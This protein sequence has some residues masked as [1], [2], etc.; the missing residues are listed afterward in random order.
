MKGLDDVDGRK[1]S[2]YTAVSVHIDGST[3]REFRPMTRVG[4]IVDPRGV[5]PFTA[6]VARNVWSTT[7]SIL[8]SEFKLEVYETN[9]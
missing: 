3:K 8:E 2:R 4:M 1:I 6:S 5:E 9:T 7:V